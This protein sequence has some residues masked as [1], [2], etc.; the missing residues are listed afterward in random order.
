MSTRILPGVPP[1]SFQSVIAPV[2][3]L[4]IWY[5]VRDLIELLAAT[6]TAV[7]LAPIGR[8][9]TL[10]AVFSASVRSRLMYPRSVSP[11]TTR[12][13][14]AFD[15]TS[16]SPCQVMLGCA[17]RNA[18]V[19]ALTL[20]SAPPPPFTMYWPPRGSC[21]AGAGRPAPPQLTA[22]RAAMMINDTVRKRRIQALLIGSNRD[23]SL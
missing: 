3:I 16:A 4:A 22:N 17:V 21:V 20:S 11:E 19:S 13:T 14:P 2:K 8:A 5:L 15:P 12:F 7:P 1:T 23:I 18:S 10:P 6:A 9:T